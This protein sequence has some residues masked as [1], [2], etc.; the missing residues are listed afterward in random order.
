MKH[1]EQVYWW[2]YD[3]VQYN[4]PEAALPGDPEDPYARILELRKLSQPTMK[5]DMSLLWI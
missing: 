1:P 5:A 4:V 3:P 2:G